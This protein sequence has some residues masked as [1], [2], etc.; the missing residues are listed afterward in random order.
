MFKRPPWIAVP[1]LRQRLL[2]RLLIVLVLLAVTS[3]AGMLQLQQADHRVRG[4]VEGS[5]SPVADVGRV[6]NDYNDS[7]Q[8]LV[9]AVLSQL[10]SAVDDA[11]TRIQSDRVDIARHW[12]ATH[13]YPGT[14]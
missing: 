9:H 5:L 11:H 3:V 12:R 7:L 13:P 6:Q 8:A 10:P 2:L 1:S 4:L 14:P